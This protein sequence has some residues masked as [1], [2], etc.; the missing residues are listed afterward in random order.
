MTRFLPLAVLA[1]AFMGCQGRGPGAGPG[2][3]PPVS[4]TAT[5]PTATRP[6]RVAVVDFVRVAQAHP[7]WG[8]LDALNHRI[9]ELEAELAL[10]A[11]VQV[12]LPQIDLGPQMRAEVEREVEQLRPEFRQQFEREAAAL[13]EEAK[14]ELDAYAAKV[15]ADTEAEFETRRA[16]LEAETRK[17]VQDRQDEA[18]KDM[19][20]FE[21]QTLEQYRMRLVNLRL[22]TEAVQQTDRQEAE[23]L[24]TQL[25]ELTKERDGKI[26]AHDKEVQT[27]L[28][29]FQQQQTQQYEAAVV[30][31]QKQ[32]SADGQ[33]LIDEKA[34]ELNAR[35]HDQLAARQAALN[36]EMNARLR[37]ELQAR[38]QTLV[39]S[40]REQAGRAQEQANAAARARVQALQAQLQAAQ[41][42]RARFLETILAEARIEAAA[43]AQEKGYDLILTQALGVV[44]VVDATD[45]LITRIKR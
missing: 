32:L 43:L 10:P 8:E 20:Q 18:T 34:G 16:A 15:R 21:Q 45:D 7:R 22:K 26:A 4:A 30:D 5:S 37:V 13:Q 39:A 35:L 36:T 41:L 28:Q 11:T 24:S 23:R 42:E 31:L 40:A 33:R 6:L 3:T 14:R 17:A 1:L 2:G 19:G 27:A 44:D 29:E 12:P 38:E 9:S 25:Q